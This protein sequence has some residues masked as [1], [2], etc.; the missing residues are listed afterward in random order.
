MQN[1]EDETS[2]GFRV[3]FLTLPMGVSAG[4]S[5]SVRGD[6][7][8]RNGTGNCGE[9]AGGGSVTDAGLLRRARRWL[10]AFAA[11]LR[12]LTEADVTLHGPEKFLQSDRLVT[13]DEPKPQK[14]SRMKDENLN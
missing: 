12:P 3:D 10:Q 4:T 6:Q 9:S 13:P 11:G 2:E 14:L 5:E 1:L 7:V 8:R